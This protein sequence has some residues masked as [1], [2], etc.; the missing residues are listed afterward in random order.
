VIG[1]TVQDASP[2]KIGN[3]AGLFDVDQYRMNFGVG[4]ILLPRMK[5]MNVFLEKRR[6]RPT[7]SLIV[8]GTILDFVAKRMRRRHFSG[9]SGGCFCCRN[10][11]ILFIHQGCSL[12][13]SV[14]VNNDFDVRLLLG[15]T[16]WPGLSDE[17]WRI[18]T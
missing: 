11:S 9:A 5:L 16:H 7:K 13:I 8:G 1:A 12:K 6:L 3:D 14:P 15:M 10:H 2:D 17:L 4:V 18:G